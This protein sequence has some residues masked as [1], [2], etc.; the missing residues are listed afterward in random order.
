MN[1]QKPHKHSRNISGHRNKTS[2]SISFLKHPF[3]ILTKNNNNKTI[4]STNKKISFSQI[5]KSNLQMYNITNEEIGIIKINDIIDTKNC[6]LVAIFKDYLIS[7]YIDE[8][9]RRIYHKN[10]IKER[11]PKFEGYYK[12][13]LTFFCNII[14]SDFFSNYILQLFSNIYS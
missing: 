4:N 14:F 3:N 1:N 7:D 5:I 6:H 8:F 10:E 12:N 9:L 11:I 2:N 13:Y